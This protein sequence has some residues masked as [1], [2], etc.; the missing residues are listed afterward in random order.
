MKDL[1]GDGEITQKDVLMGR[2]VIAKKRGGSAKKGLYGSNI[3]AKKAR[4][5]GSREGSVIKAKKL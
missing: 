3:H 2:G 4:I 5:K 1:S